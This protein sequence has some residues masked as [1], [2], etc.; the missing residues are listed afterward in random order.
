MNK[1]NKLLISGVVQGVSFRYH[2][3]EKAVQLGLSGWIQNL[4]NGRVELVLSGSTKAVES[5][6]QWAHTGPPLAKVENIELTVFQD[7][8]LDKEF[9][10]KRDGGK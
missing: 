10:I 6:I 5:M 4:A 3:H 7:E 8:I 1:K 9:V 2:A